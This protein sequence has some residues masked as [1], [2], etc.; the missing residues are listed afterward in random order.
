MGTVLRDLGKLNEAIEAFK[1]SIS[2]KP[3]YAHAY[4]NLGIC[5]QFQDKLDEA[6]EAYNACI[7]T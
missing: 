1:T 5:F 7:F 6:I 4:N 3:N 2:L